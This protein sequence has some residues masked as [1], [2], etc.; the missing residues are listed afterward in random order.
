M[1][2]ARHLPGLG[3]PLDL[4]CAEFDAA[5]DS[6]SRSMDAATDSRSWHRRYV[7]ENA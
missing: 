3:N 5:C 2:V 7:E 4:S 1:H 6:I